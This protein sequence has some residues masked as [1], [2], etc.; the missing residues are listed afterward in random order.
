MIRSGIQYFETEITDGLDIRH[1]EWL[2]LVSSLG[3]WKD[4]VAS[5][6]DE[7]NC[8]RLRLGKGEIR[9]TVLDIIE[10]EMPYT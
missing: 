9:C 5:S 4:G 3:N 2:L 1:Q 8:E 10:L 7:E 6:R